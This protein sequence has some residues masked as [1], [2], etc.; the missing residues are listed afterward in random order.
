MSEAMTEDG[1]R[2]TFRDIL[3]NRLCKVLGYFVSRR[4]VLGRMARTRG[5][6]PKIIPER[7]LIA[8]QMRELLTRFSQDTQALALGTSHVGANLDVQNAALRLWNA[9]VGNGD[10]RTAYYLYLYFRE[11]WPLGKGQVVLLGEDFWLPALQTEYTPMFYAN[12]AL[13]VITKGMPYRHAFAM[14]AHER[15]VRHFL[16]YPNPEPLMKETV[17]SPITDVKGRVAQHLRFLNFAPTEFPWLSKLREAVEADG[18]RLVRFRPPLRTDYR[19]ALE[20][21]MKARGKTGAEVWALFSDTCDGI[22]L[23]DY[24]ALEVPSEFW[25]D[26]DHLNPAGAKVFTERVAQDLAKLLPELASHQK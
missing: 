6:R 13:Q 8:K 5:R 11:R 22:P 26:C 24:T 9:G 15:V 4:S 7:R 16:A 19:E 18:R 14:G 10:W 17:V 3:E 23:L 12:I 20:A 2:F 1:I 21:A 25:T